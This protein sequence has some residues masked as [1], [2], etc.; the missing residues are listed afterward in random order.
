[1]CVCVCT[2]FSKSW[3]LNIS[4]HTIAPDI[5]SLFL[6][7]S[8]ILLVEKC[9][10]SLYFTGFSKLPPVS[11]PLLLPFLI[12][13]CSLFSSSIPLTPDTPEILQI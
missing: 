13:K 10:A 1:M 12:L 4:Q 5:L 3:L 8:S 2:P 9:W 11:E 6:C 7:A